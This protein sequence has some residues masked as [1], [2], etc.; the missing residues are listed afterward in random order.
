MTAPSGSEASPA[1]SHLVGELVEALCQ[2]GLDHHHR[3]LDRL[4]ARLLGGL[5]ERTHDAAAIA[6]LVMWL[7][8]YLHRAF[9]FPFRR[10]GGQKPMPLVIALQAV[11]FNCVNAWT[12]GRWLFSSGPRHED[13]WLSDPRFA[14]GLAL[15]VVG[16]GIN[17]HSDGVLFALR[18]PGE[19]GYKI[20]RRGL[21]RLVSSP[22]YFGEILEWWGFAIATW[23]LAPVGF[24]IWT[25]AN[26][27]PRALSNHRWYRQQFPDY[28]KDRRALIPYLF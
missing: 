1:R 15:F 6:F 2:D 24:A 3:G 5:G 22:N 18:A 27:A 11:V 12:C 20:P 10:R 7:A 13:S 19:T 4:G 14:L 21:Y 8:H 9:I 25:T 23:S 28:P 16:Y 17:L 26:L